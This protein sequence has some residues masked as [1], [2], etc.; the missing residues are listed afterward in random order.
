MTARYL[1]VSLAFAL[2][3]IVGRWAAR[4]DVDGTIRN[5]PV[6]A[7]YTCLAVD[8]RSL[9]HLARLQSCVPAHAHCCAILVWGA[10]E[11]PGSCIGFSDTWE[12]RS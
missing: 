5:T 12:P 1:N 8:T 11:R 6:R 3:N 4:C 10:R 2:L 9:E 7:A